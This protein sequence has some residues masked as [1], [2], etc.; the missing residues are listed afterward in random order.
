MEEQAALLPAV[1]LGAVWFWSLFR[2][3]A[4]PPIAAFLI[5]LLLDLLG[6]MPLGIGAL[7]TLSVHGLAGRWRRVLARHGFAAAWLAFAAVASLMAAL[8]YV[9][10]MVLTGRLVP[11]GPAVFQ[12]V[13]S[14]ALYPP[15][16]I[17]LAR[18]HRTIA[19]P[20]RA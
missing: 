9:A 19:D 1:T 2:P 20:E 12:A 7:S 6:W 8:G 17:L 10:T 5:G 14:A 3:V 11:P 18:A 13:L 4:M 16:A 15:L